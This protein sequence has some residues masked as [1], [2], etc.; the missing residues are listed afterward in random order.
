MTLDE[1]ALRGGTTLKANGKDALQK[2]M[3]LG[4]SPDVLD[5]SALATYNAFDADFEVPDVAGVVG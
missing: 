5:A 3:H 2:S 4:R 1:R